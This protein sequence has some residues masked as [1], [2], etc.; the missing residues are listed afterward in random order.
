[1][2]EANGSNQAEDGIR[3]S[4]LQRGICLQGGHRHIM[5]PKKSENSSNYFQRVNR[6][7]Q[8]GR[9]RKACAHTQH[10]LGSIE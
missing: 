3:R 4:Q 8:E 5:T 6:I 9:V 2:T 1:M 7:L 10:K